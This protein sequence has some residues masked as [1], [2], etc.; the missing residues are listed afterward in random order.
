[1]IGN[2]IRRY[3]Q[4]RNLTIDRGIAYGEWAG[5]YIT[6]EEGAGWKSVSFAVCWPENEAAEL[7]HT[8]LSDEEIRK[9]Y[10]ITRHTVSEN[11]PATVRVLFQDTVGTMTKIEEFI[12]VMTEKLTELGVRGAGVCHLCGGEIGSVGHAVMIQKTAVILHDSCARRLEEEHKANTAHK[13]EGS[14]ALGAV[15]AILGGILG[16]IPFAALYALGWIASFFGFLIGIAAKKG[17]ELLGGRNGKIKGVVILLVTVL[18]VVLAEFV[19]I[20]AVNLPPAL[21]MGYD[22]GDTI[23]IMAHWAIY[24]QPVAVFGEIAMGWLFA[25]LGIYRMLAEIFRS[26]PGKSPFVTLK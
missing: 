24:E 22:L 12:D 1:M 4:N 2:G 25:F 20:V 13:K 26:A 23:V 11:K 21:E 6:L 19:A 14:V 16:A 15:G 10:R 17:Y 5:H 7:I 3:A 8:Y 9:T 18:A